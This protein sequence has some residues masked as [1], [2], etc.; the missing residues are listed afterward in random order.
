MGNKR[1]L[2][3][4]LLCIPILG[5][6][7]DLYTP[8]LPNITYFFN[9]TTYMTKTSISIFVLGAFIAMPIFGSMSDIYGRRKIIIYSLIVNILSNICIIFSK[10]I[11]IF[12][13]FR[14]IGGAAL[15]AVGATMRAIITDLYTG[16]NLK[17]TSTLI[18]TSWAIGPIVAPFIGGVVQQNFGWKIIFIILALYSTLC[19]ILVL[20]YIP[21]SRPKDTRI[22]YSNILKNYITILKNQYFLTTVIVCGL[23]YASLTYFG[24]IGSIYIQNKLG[25]SSIS[26]GRLALIVGFAYIIG[27][28]LSRVL[29]K[30]IEKATNILFL[31][32][33]TT[34]IICL[35][36][37]SITEL[38]LVIII[39]NTIITSIILGMIYASFFSASLAIFPKTAGSAGALAS[40]FIM[41]S[42]SI[43]SFIVSSITITNATTFIFIYFITLLIAYL[44]YI[45]QRTVSL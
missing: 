5:I 28:V 34:N 15:G 43:S 21:E 10:D 14:F 35:I 29:F 23:L 7:I 33:L 26:F 13:I 11:V 31:M 17:K 3:A 40:A 2:I 24:L 38:N 30:Y 44:I 1:P 27:T 39:F 6:G 42:V 20:K 8:A 37:S 9:T 45:Y 25:Y 22:A 41:F 16:T 36:F 18:T 19:F 12:L 32:I 4:I